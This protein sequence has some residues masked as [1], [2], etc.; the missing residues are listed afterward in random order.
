MDRPKTR[1]RYVHVNSMHRHQQGTNDPVDMDVHLHRPIKNVLRC[2]VKQFSMSN[3]FHNIRSGSNV[4]RWA[5]FNIPDGMSS[6]VGRV[7]S[8]T[9]PTGYYE[10][11]TLCS[12]IN[13]LIANMTDHKV[14]DVD[15]Y[16]QPLGISFSQDASTYKI[17]IDFTNTSPSSKWFCP[18]SR[19]HSLWNVL[20]FVDSQIVNASKRKIMG[21]SQQT[22]SSQ[23]DYTESFIV[24]SL[25][26]LIGSG[27]QHID[28]N[29]THEV[30]PNVPSHI[31]GVLPTLFESPSS[32]YLCSD[33]LTSGSTFESRN[34]PEHT[35]TECVPM[36][37]LEFIQFTS[38]RY[39]H[40]HY[41]AQLPHYHYLNEQNVSRFDIQLKS[42][43]GI[44]LYFNEIGHFNIVLTFETV[45][46]DEYSEEFVKAYNAEGYDIL[47]RPDNIKI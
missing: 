36:P 45:D 7:F 11:D 27:S 17:K 9:I 21:F 28:G 15:P 31:Q 39:T 37:I 42:A 18:I 41:T 19:K 5:E 20:G 46:H 8:V 4:L 38:S 47:H 3:T 30:E 29:A 6:Y 2:Y 43:D 44:P 1:T 35:H 10:T 25:S 16:E 40:F 32:I 14:Y 33:T 13:S 34:N 23:G 24:D 22:G 26:A 12:T